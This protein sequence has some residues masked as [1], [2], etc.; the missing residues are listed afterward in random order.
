MEFSNTFSSLCLFKT[1]STLLLSLVLG[2]PNCLYSLDFAESFQIIILQKSLQLN[3]QNG[4]LLPAGALTNTKYALLSKQF[5][6]KCMSFLLSSAKWIQWCPTLCD[7]MD[8]SPPGSSLHGAFQARILGWG[9]ISFSRESSQPRN[10]TH[11]SY[12]SYIGRRVLYHSH[13]L[14]SPFDPV[15]IYYLGE[16]FLIC[17]N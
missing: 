16:Y 6:S 14:E 7:P 9:D 5:N 2:C 10:W 4:V 8:C 1:E 15:S 3:H 12:I 11:I 13:H 17:K